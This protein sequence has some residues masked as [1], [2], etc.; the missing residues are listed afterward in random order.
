MVCKLH[1]ALNGLKQAPRAWFH[2]LK[3][4]L[5]SW[6]FTN[7]Q[8][9]NSL[10]ITRYQGNMLDVLVYVDDIIIIGARN[11]HIQQFINKLHQTFALKD[12]GDL[13]MFLDFEV[14][15]DSTGFVFNTD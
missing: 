7:S 15:R 8:S 5:F 4:Q 14:H 12:I 10:F 2:R 3:S 11:D 13:N 6:G 1:K 9:D